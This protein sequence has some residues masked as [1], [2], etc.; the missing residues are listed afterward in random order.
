[1]VQPLYLAHSTFSFWGPFPVL[2]QVQ[3]ASKA[4]RS[5][6][7]RLLQMS[8]VWKMFRLKLSLV[9][10]CGGTGFDAPFKG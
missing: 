9:V 2:P 4:R 8:S 7:L 3:Q 5:N 10:S 6:H 1:M